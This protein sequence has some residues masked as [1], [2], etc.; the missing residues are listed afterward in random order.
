MSY[1]ILKILIFLQINKWIFLKSFIR[2]TAFRVLPSAW[3]MSSRLHYLLLW[4]THHLQVELLP[5]ARIPWS[6]RRLNTLRFHLTKRSWW[7]NRWSNSLA[8]L[9]LPCFIPWSFWFATCTDRLTCFFLV[10]SC[11]HQGREFSSPKSDPIREG[12]RQHQL[13]FQQVLPLETYW[14]F[15][16]QSSAQE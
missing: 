14:Q 4:S 12:R 16:S 1:L 3:A 15:Q 7:W 13:F 9:W 5:H 6:C 2:P 10:P 11:T 8:P